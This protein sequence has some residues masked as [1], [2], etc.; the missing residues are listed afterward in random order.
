ME[1]KIVSVVDVDSVHC[2]KISLLNVL[3]MYYTK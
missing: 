1:S 3:N 2:V